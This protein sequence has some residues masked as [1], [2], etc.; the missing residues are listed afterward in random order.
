VHLKGALIPR[1]AGAWDI[2]S[3]ELVSSKRCNRTG[4]SVI[5]TAYGKSKLTVSASPKKMLVAFV[6]SSSLGFLVDCN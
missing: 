5:V 6:A 4:E 1:D 2:Y 3:G